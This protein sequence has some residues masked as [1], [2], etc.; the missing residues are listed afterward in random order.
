MSAPIYETPNSLSISFFFFLSVKF[1]VISV[2]LQYNTFLTLA[3]VTSSAEMKPFTRSFRI[4]RTL[5]DLFSTAVVAWEDLS[6]V[7]M[8]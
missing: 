1:Y 7:F 8:H 2:A 4:S 3:L 6:A 5:L